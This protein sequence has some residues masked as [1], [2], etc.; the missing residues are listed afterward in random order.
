MASPTRLYANGGPPC[1]GKGPVW[2]TPYTWGGPQDIGGRKWLP[3]L[4]DAEKDAI[5]LIEGNVLWATD[6]DGNRVLPPPGLP[7]PKFDEDLKKEEAAIQV[8]AR[9]RGEGNEIRDTT[10]MP[11]EWYRGNGTKANK[12]ERAVHGKDA[13]QGVTL[14]CPYHKSTGEQFLEDLGKTAGS[15]APFLKVVSVIVSYV[16]VLGTA[17][18]FIINAS[19]SLARGENISEAMLEGVANSI[20]GQPM[21]G[22]AFRAVVSIA[23]GE[24]FDKAA[25]AALPVDQTTRDIITAAVDVFL[26]IAAGQPVTDV[27][28]SQVYSRLPEEGKRAMDVAKRLV[29]GENVLGVIATEVMRDA[30]KIAREKGPEAAR[31]FIAETGFQAGVEQLSPG[32][33]DAVM[34]ALVA[35]EANRQQF[36]GVFDST[37]KNIGTNDALASKGQKIINS[38]ARWRNRPLT[39][40]RA[41]K[42][43][44]L[45]RKALDPMSGALVPR[46]DIFEISD[47][48]RRGFDVAIGLCEGVKE[49]SQVQQQVRASLARLPVQQ[50]F[51]SGQ[52]VQFERT[53]TEERKPPSVT[54]TKT[55]SALSAIASMPRK[56]APSMSRMASA[57]SVATAV[58]APS[59]TLPPPGEPVVLRP[60]QSID[61]S[62]RTALTNRGIALSNANPEIRSEK[63]GL[64]SE[65]ARRGFDIGT[66]LAEDGPQSEISRV[67]S[68]LDPE[69][70]S[71]F[72]AALEAKARR[73]AGKPLPSFVQEAMASPVFTAEQKVSPEEIKRVQRAGWVAYYKQKRMP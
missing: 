30:A 45:S 48:W 73:A 43:F 1:A 52:F 61:G 54:Q 35:G 26:P 2:G 16:P 58:T 70:L 15:V 42:F 22:S 72:Q 51:D 11:S 33:K 19:L 59:V 9:G 21:S 34:M 36:I 32:M 25:I 28:L 65:L 63:I 50:G 47:D 40:V 3:G 24:R 29:S 62:V 53:I 17:V 5:L 12:E 14:V 31:K 56:V 7:H 6:Q 44:T 10:P 71:G 41:A 64:P 55:A 66:A 60:G 46:T 37:E 39:E 68:T 8:I 20:P 4:H 57:A 23:K 49:D 18:S 27:L 13:H 67:A 38:G 69:T